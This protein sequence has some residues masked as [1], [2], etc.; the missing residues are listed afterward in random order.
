MVTVAAD[1]TNPNDIAAELPEIVRDVHPTP[2]ADTLTGG[3]VPIIDDVRQIYTD[4]GVHV[5]RVFLVH[6]Q[7][8]GARV[9]EGT[10][11]EIARREIL[12]APRVRAMDGVTAVLR[13]FGLTEEGSIMVDRISA[14]YTEDDLAGHTPDMVDPVKSRTSRSNVEFF[15]EVAENRASTPASPRRR[16]VP[17]AAPHLSRDAL[18]WRVTLTKQDYNRARDA[19]FKRTAQ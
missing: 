1:R 6:V 7:W 8:S 16:F 2:I 5:Y 4:L 12:P 3:L 11:I 14:K 10:P 9:G 19:T 17:T 18:Q 15:Y 13:S